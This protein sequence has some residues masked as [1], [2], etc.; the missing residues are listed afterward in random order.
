MYCVCV[1]VDTT[2]ANYKGMRQFVESCI[3]HFVE[4]VGGM[5]CK[6]LHGHFKPVWKPL[7]LNHFKEVVCKPV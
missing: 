7:S 2:T 6:G 3:Q 5:V 4:Y 1:R